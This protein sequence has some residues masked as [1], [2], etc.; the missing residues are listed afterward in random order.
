MGGIIFFATTMLDEVCSFY[1]GQ[2]GC[3]IWLEQADCKIL[4]HGN[5]LFGFCTRP[6][7]DLTGMVT[8]FYDSR[9]EV[10]VLYDRFKDIA[11]SK[12]AN[13]KKY[14]IYNFFANDPEG[15]NIEFQSFNHPV[16]ISY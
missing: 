1:A 12:P 9:E 16:E 5:M 2:I 3:E 10:D 15:R 11:S 4:K 7:A 8:F 13:N 14:D 6:K